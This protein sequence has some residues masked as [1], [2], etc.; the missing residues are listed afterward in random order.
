MVL[1]D[2]IEDGARKRRKLIWIAVLA[3][4]GGF[5]GYGLG[6]W[7]GRS[8]PG[9]LESLGFSP[10]VA[11]AIAA[12]YVVTALLVLVG[13][14]SPNMGANFLNVEDADEIREM[15]RLLTASGIALLG[16]G[17]VLAVAALAG[18]LEMIPSGAALTIALFGIGVAV[19]FTVRTA[20]MSDELSRAV[21]KDAG[22]LSYYLVFVVVGGWALLAALGYVQAPGPLDIMSMIWGLVLVASFWVCGRRGLL[23][24][25]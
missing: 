5:L 24:M 17:T 11:I 6:Y 21:S 8:A 23:A 7:L 13:L 19:V 14:I 2:N 22:E 20:S 4:I 1:D 12:M 10:I 15:R 9:S 18:P 16:F 3:A 25:R